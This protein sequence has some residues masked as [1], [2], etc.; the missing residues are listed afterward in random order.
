MALEEAGL[1]PEKVQMLERVLEG[2]RGRTADEI[3]RVVT[4]VLTKDDFIPMQKAEKT[5]SAL[6]TVTFWLF[7]I[8]LAIVLWTIA[9]SGGTP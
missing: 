9:A 1:R 3:G 8:F 6:R 4:S 5:R 2:Q 7:M